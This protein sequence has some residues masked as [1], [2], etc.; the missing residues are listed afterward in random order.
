VLAANHSCIC[1]LPS[2]FV[3]LC[4]RSGTLDVVA[5]GYG[6]GYVFYMPG[7]SNGTFGTGRVVGLLEGSQPNMVD[8]GDMTGDGLLDVV[9]A[10]E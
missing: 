5:C 9:V 1:K 6:N 3:P 8:V 7:Y 10:G 2:L 4:R